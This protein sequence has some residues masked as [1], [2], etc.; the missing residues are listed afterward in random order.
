MA[1]NNTNNRGRDTGFEQKPLPSLPKDYLKNGY[2]FPNVK[3]ITGT[4]TEIARGLVAKEYFGAR[5]RNCKTNSVS[6]IRKFY[7]FVVNNYDSYNRHAITEEQLIYKMSQ[8][9]SHADYAHSKKVITQY[10]VD[11]I[12]ANVNAC[13]TAD[14]VKAF[15][16]HFMSVYEEFNAISK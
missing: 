12:K 2:E 8:L 4:A 15:K 6:G 1:Y 11:F 3:L 7:D 16:E 10:L 5:D 14:D 13:K 9:K